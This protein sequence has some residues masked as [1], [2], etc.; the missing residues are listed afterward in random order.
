[1]DVSVEV[2]ELSISFPYFLKKQHTLS[3]YI[4]MSLLLRK[5]GFKLRSIEVA[6]II[7]LP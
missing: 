2:M 5:A 4:Y 7:G 3:N 6:W 1:M